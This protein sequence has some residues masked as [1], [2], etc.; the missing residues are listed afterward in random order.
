MADLLDT[1]IKN[2]RRKTGQDA[3][4]A[5]V[6]DV[7]GV[8]YEPGRKG[9]VRVTYPSSAGR[10]FPTVVRLKVNIQLA[11]GTPVIVDYD[12]TGQPAIVDIDFD[13]MEAGDWNPHTGQTTNPSVNAVDLNL[14][15]IL[16]CG[17]FGSSK[18]LYVYLLNFKYIRN[19]TVHTFDG[20]DGGIDLS[21]YVPGASNNWCV[22][23]IFVKPDDTSEVISSTAQNISEPITD[24]D[25]QECVT[26][27]TDGSFPVA[28][29][30]LTNGQTL[31]ADTDKR[32][33]ARQWIN[34]PEND[35][36][37]V[38]TSGNT[39]TTLAS[40]AV[41][42]LS[43][44]TITGTFSGVKSDYS[45]AIAGTFVAGVRRA[46]GGNA[47]LV[48][49]NVTSNEDSGGTPSFT[50]DADTGTQTARLRCT[51][52]SAETWNWSVKYQ[53]LVT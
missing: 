5:T 44:L 20:V 11:P 45:A 2:V 12:R 24:T 8:V 28:F 6:G 33:D 31:I 53:C 18:P 40:V 3:R 32:W 25:F 21:G 34:V 30:Q 47:T 23:G 37:T 49:V 19:G 13:G 29:W 7:D 48:G 35:Y 10:T 16:L 15:P 14:S 42:E 52:I 4:S 50:V 17:A 9:Y 39:Q 46:S 1:A 38:A 22:V 51:G 27:S 41:A 26:A 36:A 43:L